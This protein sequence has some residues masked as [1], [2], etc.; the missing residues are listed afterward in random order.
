MIRGAQS[1]LYSAAAAFLLASPLEAADKPPF[2]V[3]RSA[4]S[5]QISRLFRKTDGWVGADAAY[6]V[7]L[8]A[9]RTLWTFGDTWIGRI[10]GGKRIHCTMVNNSI[11]LQSHGRLAPQLDFRWGRQDG[12]P[13]AFWRPEIAGTYYWP[14]DGAMVDGKLYVFLHVIRPKPDNP[15]PF[16]FEAVEDLVLQVD[17]PLEDLARW[18]SRIVK[19]GNSARVINFGVACLTDG[20]HLYAYCSYPPAGKRLAG[21]PTVLARIDRQHLSALDMSAWQYWCN[22]GAP[23][24]QGQWQRR[25]EN[26]V[27]LFEDGAPEMSV[28]RVAGIAGFIAAYMPPFSRTIFLRHAPA[29]QGPWSERIA[30]YRCPEKDPRILVYSAKAHPQLAPGKLRLALTY[31]RN[32]E[33][34]ARHF[35]QPEIYF[36]QGVEVLLAPTASRK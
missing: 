4:A 34:F 24:H 14:G 18:R 2:T 8:S 32:S 26:P 29:P 21:H 35:D 22:A 15:E 19:I 11:A 7:P 16:Q 31:C 30:A 10:R 33:Q 36:P 12:K 9:A 25:L 17:N 1:V 13:V 6:S 27:I 20:E 3:A 28:K 5:P 23:G